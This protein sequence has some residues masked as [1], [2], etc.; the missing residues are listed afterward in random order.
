MRLLVACLLSFCSAF[1]QH[2][3]ASNTSIGVG[4]SPKAVITGRVVNVISNEPIARASLSLM[5]E[6][7]EG[8]R[9]PRSFT[10]DA[11]GEFR[12]ENLSTGRYRLH[13]EKTGY[14]LIKQGKP[15]RDASFSITLKSNEEVRKVSLQ[16]APTAA[17]T[18]RLVNEQGEPVANVSVAALRA[19]RLRRPTSFQDYSDS[20]TTNDL[21]EY[22]LFGLAPG[23]YHLRASFW[24]SMELIGSGSESP[25]R[26]APVFY[27]G[28]AAREE[29]AAIQLRPGDEVRADFQLVPAQTV[30]VKGKVGRNCKCERN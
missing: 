17:V 3:P 27:P 1:A 13:V 12:I 29:A 9:Q 6:G 5:P 30:S 7:S 8:L 16:M 22:R 24:G 19:S 2:E 23:S 26:Y 11:K 10:S 25:V 21:G 14:V 20:A 15:R 18:G 4:K 28:V